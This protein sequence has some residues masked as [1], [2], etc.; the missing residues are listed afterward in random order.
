MSHHEVLVEQLD[1]WSIDHGDLS[2]ATT[3]EER[4]NNA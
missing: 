2:G 3:L 1:G 4:H